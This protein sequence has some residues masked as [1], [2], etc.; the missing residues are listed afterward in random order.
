MIKMSPLELNRKEVAV[1]SKNLMKTKRIFG[2]VSINRGL[3]LIRLIHFRFR[4]NS[5]S[6]HRRVVKE[7]SSGSGSRS[8]S[9]ESNLSLDVRGANGV[10]VGTP[11]P[12][13]SLDLLA[14]GNTNHDEE[15][16]FKLIS[17]L[18]AC[19]EAIGTKNT[20]ES[21]ASENRNRISSRPELGFPDSQN[22]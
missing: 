14:I 11:N 21:P 1:K 5:S 4:R 18:L 15:V 16:R 20:S 2:L 22:P 3:F 7:T 9:P 10:G 6:S 8:S 17:L 19:L 12:N 13:Q